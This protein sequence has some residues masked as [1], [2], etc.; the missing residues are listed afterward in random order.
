MKDDIKQVAEVIY[1]GLHSQDFV[2]WYEY[3]F[4]YH[5]EGETNCR[6]KEQIL[7]DIADVFMLER[8]LAQ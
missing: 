4:T 5:V 1:R 3:P 7:E 6:S 2:D 8:F